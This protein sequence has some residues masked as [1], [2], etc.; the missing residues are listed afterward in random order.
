MSK[1]SCYIALLR[2]INVSGHKKIL[3]KDLTKLLEGCG[4][5]NVKT[6]IQSGNVVFNSAKNN[7]L[8]VLIHNKIKE[9]YGWEVSIL[10]VT[11]QKVKDILEQCPFDQDKQLSSYY[12]LPLIAP[13]AQNVAKLKEYSFEAEEYS[14][15]NNCI[16]LFYDQGAGKA[17]MTNNF[18]ENKLKVSCTS[19]NH[20]TMLKLLFMANQA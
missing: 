15:T 19:R 11:A 5:T 12:C 1:D 16:Y 6:Y 7:N 13:Q 2:G 18:I 14:I 9:A 17:K 3:M 8:D 10:V 20:R 4:F